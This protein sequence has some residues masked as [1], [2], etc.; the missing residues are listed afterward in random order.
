MFLRYLSGV[1]GTNCGTSMVMV[2]HALSVE[3]SY[4]KRRDVHG[5]RF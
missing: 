2:P 4:L 3:I 5:R 1:K